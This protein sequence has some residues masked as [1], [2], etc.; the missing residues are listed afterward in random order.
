MRESLVELFFQPKNG[1]SECDKT[2]TIHDKNTEKIGT[3]QAGQAV[4]IPLATLNYECAWSKKTTRKKCLEEEIGPK[5]QPK[6]K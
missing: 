2:Q 4:T 3:A 1:Y 6:M 5:T